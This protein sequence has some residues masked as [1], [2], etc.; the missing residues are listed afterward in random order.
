MALLLFY[1]FRNLLTRKVTTALTASGMALVV[2]VFTA[3][4]MLAE[5]LQHTLVQTGEHDNVVILRK[6]AESEV[7]SVID[8]NQASIIE[9]QPEIALEENGCKLLAKELVILITLQKR[10]SDNP[11]NVI[12]R[13]IGQRSLHL[14]PQVKIIAGRMPKTGTLEIVA[15]QSIA[16]GFKNTGLGKT[17]RFAMREWTVV[18]IFDAGNT[19]FSSEIWGDAEQLMQ[20]FRR[21]VFSSVIFRLRERSAF[22]TV[23]QRIENDPRL[24]LEATR[25]VNYYRKQSEMMATFLRI[26]GIS[27][28]AIFSIGAVIGAMI[29]M[30][31]AVANRTAEIGTLRAIGFQR[32]S[33]LLAFLLESLILGFFGGCTGLIFASLLQFVGVSTMNFQTFSELSFRFSI[34]REIAGKAMSFALFMGFSGGILP[35]MRASHM[36]IVNALRKS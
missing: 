6:S 3:I 14:R 4:I 25:E 24:T 11:A 29:T 27:L 33:I 8:R 34:T 17:I 13:G 30:Y 12:I 19:G 2:F 9:T 21:P 26:L 31:S 28:T 32:S 23:K 18:G 7:Q 20:A 22:Q 15:G 10:G 36:N 5:G 35:A 1:S 16:K